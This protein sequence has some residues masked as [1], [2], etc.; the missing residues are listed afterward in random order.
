M[1]REKERFTVGQSPIL[2][3]QTTHDRVPF[4]RNVGNTDVML[5]IKKWPMDQGLT[6]APGVT[7]PFPNPMMPTDATPIFAVCPDGEGKVEYLFIR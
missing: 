4:I 3:C 6:L 2:I 1:S 5:D 7:L